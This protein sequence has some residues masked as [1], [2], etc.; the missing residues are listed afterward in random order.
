MKRILL[1]VVVIVV[2]VCYAYAE[3]EKEL[4]SIEREYFKSGVLKVEWNFGT[5]IYKEFYR[6]GKLKGE[7]NIKEGKL[8]GIY[9]EYYESGALKREV[10]YQSGKRAEIV[11]PPESVGS[12]LCSGI[13]GGL[14]FGI[15]GYFIGQEIDIK[16]DPIKEEYP[17]TIYISEEAI[18]GFAAGYILG[19]SFGVYRTGNRDNETGSYLT[20]LTGS[21]LGGL[22]GVLPAPIGA[23]I[24][25]SSTRRYRDRSVNETGFINIK[26]GQVIVSS[27]S[28]YCYADSLKCKTLVQHV[29]LLNVHF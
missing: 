2:L 19:S 5:C 24:G 28:I 8:Y 27:P 18:Y 20:T 10:N 23:T 22:L 13:F 26:N 14:I 1:S 6:S 7:C 4:D 11:K 29:D 9:K 21:I 25:F 16:F 12:L 17:G 3:G 15:S